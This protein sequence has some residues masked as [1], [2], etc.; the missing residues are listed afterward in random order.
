MKKSGGHILKKIKQL[1]I[2]N[3]EMESTALA[4]FCN[5][6]QIPATMIAVT[7]LDRMLGDQ[8]I[9]SPELLAKYADHAQT[10]AINYLKAELRL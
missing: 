1:N 8:I 3:F 7:L 2:L 6:A 9:V 5:R 4:S 10:V